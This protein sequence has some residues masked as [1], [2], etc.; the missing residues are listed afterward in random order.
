MK[1]QPVNGTLNDNNPGNN[2]SDSVNKQDTS[3]SHPNKSTTRF[4]L[5]DTEEQRIENMKI[6][7]SR[8]AKHT[9]ATNNGRNND[10]VIK[11][12]GHNHDTRSKDN[13]KDNGINGLSFGN[14][15]KLNGDENGKHSTNN[16]SMYSRKTLKEKND[17][18][19]EN[20][21]LKRKRDEEENYLEVD[22]DR[23]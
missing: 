4:S 9:N 23:D 19:L 13:N 8:N 6:S 3:Q 15:N 21:G 22:V 20:R 16:K 12:N 10:E 11:L 5:E 2:M 1:N 7:E 14:K 18:K 17:D